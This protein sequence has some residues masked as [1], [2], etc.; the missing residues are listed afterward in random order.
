VT[1]NRV[2]EKIEQGQLE[3]TVAEFPDLQSWTPAIRTLL[4]EGKI[5]RMHVQDVA[6]RLIKVVVEP[7]ER[8]Q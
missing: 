4:E 5:K 1:K 8:Q 2:L 3:F 7:L 6:G